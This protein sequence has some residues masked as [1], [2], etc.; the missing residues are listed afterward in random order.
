MDTEKRRKMWPEEVPLTE[1][2]MEKFGVVRRDVTNPEEGSKSLEDH[3]TKRAADRI[4]QPSKPV[5]SDSKGRPSTVD[6]KPP[7][8]QS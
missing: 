5:G 6:P 3:M 1:E 4:A 7:V 2:M 8:V